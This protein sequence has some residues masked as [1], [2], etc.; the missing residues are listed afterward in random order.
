MDVVF[1]VKVDKNSVVGNDVEIFV[2]SFVDDSVVS[3]L[4]AVDVIVVR[5]D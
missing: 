1:V 2:L 4:S 3:V 5:V